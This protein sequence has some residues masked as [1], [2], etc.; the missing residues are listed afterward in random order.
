[1]PTIIDK[2]LNRDPV[3]RL[4]TRGVHEVKAHAYFARL[5]WNNLLRE[6]AHFVPQLDDEEDTS[7]FDS[8][9]TDRKMSNLAT[10]A[11]Y[12]LV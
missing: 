7:Y 2:L 3:S 12:V 4:G 9:S 8:E 10:L 11:Q 1:M 6:K 5:D